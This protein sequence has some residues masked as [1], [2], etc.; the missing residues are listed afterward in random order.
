M[1]NN[2]V[3]LCAVLGVDNQKVVSRTHLPRLLGK[4]NRA[5]FE[6]LLSRYAKIELEE[7]AK[8]WF[9]G[10]GKELRGSIEK[11]DNRG[12][13]SVQIVSHEDRAVIG[14]A[15]YNGT[16][17]SEKPCLQQLMEHTEV[18]SQQITA[19]ALHLHPSMTESVHGASGIFVIGLKGNQ[20]ELL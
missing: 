11:E 5:A 3:K 8:K 9:A 15:F 6:Q 1:E 13:V 17:E 2:Q 14:Q 4:V 20:K 12:E 18:H 16:K 19:D 7:G 10:D